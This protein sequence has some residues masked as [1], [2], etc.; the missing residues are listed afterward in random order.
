M[1][2]VS[3]CL[4]GIKCRYD[5]KSNPDKKVIKLLNKEVLIPVC[6]EQ[7]GGLKTPRKGNGILDGDGRS[8]VSGNAQVIDRG[9][10][11]VTKN[12]IRGA[13][14]TLKIVKLYNIK[15]AILKQ[16]SPSCGCGLAFQWKKINGKWSNRRHKGNG[17]TTTLLK[18]EGIKI[19]T[20]EEIK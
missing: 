18:R 10:K 16:G 11:D 13:K 20:E 15:E 6:P 5:A 9:R 4:L 19:L 1:R 7:L 8:V 2:I 12:F 17:V 3:A 14:E